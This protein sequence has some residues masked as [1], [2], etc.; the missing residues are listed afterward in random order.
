MEKRSYRLFPFQ[1][2]Q[3]QLLKKEK[4][5]YGVHLK[6]RGLAIDKNLAV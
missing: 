1:I 3:R 6:D 4:H 5:V 2:L